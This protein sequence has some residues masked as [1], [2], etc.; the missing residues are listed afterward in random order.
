MKKEILKLI[1]IVSLI[2]IIGCTQN[3]DN[4]IIC[5]SPYIKSSFGC[6]LDKNNNL[7][8]DREEDQEE[9]KKS[10]EEVIVNVIQKP[11]EEIIER[12]K[13]LEKLRSAHKFCNQDLDYNFMEICRVSGDKFRLLVANEGKINI[14]RFKGEFIMIDNF[15]V[16]RLLYFDSGVGEGIRFRDRESDTIFLGEEPIAIRITPI[17]VENGTIITCSKKSQKIGN[18]Y[19]PLK[20]E[21][22]R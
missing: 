11:R 9:I 2:F 14:R 13:N 22:C 8:C 17:I 7:I 3:I 20:M 1:L 21:F 18:V 12:Q 6:C 5:N 10:L 16:D 19:S 4:I 15:I